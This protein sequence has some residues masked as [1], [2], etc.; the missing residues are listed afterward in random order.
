[1]HEIW[2]GNP[3]KL[4]VIGLN[5]QMTRQNRHNRMQI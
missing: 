3:S 1:M 5:K 4:K 2:D